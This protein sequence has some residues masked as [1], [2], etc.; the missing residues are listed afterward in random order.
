LDTV[1][2]RNDYVSSFTDAVRN[3][4]RISSSYKREKVNTGGG[5]G[6]E[7]RLADMFGEAMERDREEQVLFEVGLTP[8][9]MMKMIMG[10][11]K[12]R[13]VLAN[14]KYIKTMQADAEKMIKQYVTDVV[15][16]ARRLIESLSLDALVK[17]AKGKIDMT[18]LNKLEGNER[19][20]AEKVLSEHAK[21]VL[22][23]V[24][25]KRLTKKAKILPDE[26]KT[27]IQRGIEAIEA[28]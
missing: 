16:E 11:D 13:R 23:E 19:T 24:A 14:S 25:K 7:A 12:V 20:Q 8:K 1:A 18:A 10:Q 6:L 2:A 5:G 21:G 9:N 26:L 17:M 3:K 22:K 27:L 28:L 15:R 4:F